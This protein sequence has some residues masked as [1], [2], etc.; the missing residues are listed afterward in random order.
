MT[1]DIRDYGDS[2]TI[3]IYTDDN[4]ILKKLR[5]WKACQR[6]IDYEVWRNCD[7]RS[8]FVV[9]YDLYF[10]KKEENHIRKALGLPI[11][12]RNRSKA[13]QE[14]TKKMT[15]AGKKFRFL[16][17]KTEAAEI[18]GVLALKN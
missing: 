8:R 2:K 3:V 18:V 6:I 10:D 4:A 11:K 14:Q 5:V 17:Q 12:K 7:P 13:Q 16:P 15:E 1:L 9:A